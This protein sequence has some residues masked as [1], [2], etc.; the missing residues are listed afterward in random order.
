MNFLKQLIKEVGDEHTSL[1]EDGA[2]SAEFTGYIDTGSLIFNAALSGTIFGGMPDNK[3]LALAGQEAVGKTF[4][5]LGLCKHF[6]DTHDHAGI[7][8]YMSEPAVTVKMLTDRGIDPK[9]LMFS[10]PMTVQEFKFAVIK[11]ADA[12]VALE[13]QPPLMMVLDSLGNLSTTKEMEDSTEGKDVL[14]MTRAKVIRG[15]F[16]TIG[17]KLARAGIPMVVTNHTYDQMD[18]Y[19]PKMMSGGGGLKYAGDMIAFLTKSKDQDDDKE[20][21]VH[22]DIVHISMQK[23]RFSRPF[24]KVD[25]LL[26]YTTGLDR[27]YGLLPLAV[28]AGVFTKL[29]KGYEYAGKRVY[30]KEIN[31]SPEEFYTEDV[32]RVLDDTARKEFQYG[33]H[34]EDD[35]DTEEVK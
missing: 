3:V 24:T 14:D 27:Y 28:K 2:S 11:F 21:K 35:G 4:F 13:E 10:E 32:L 26:N 9:R 33:T 19:K 12:Y 22:G 25:V 20:K 17:L 29:P 1:A 7:A 31:A 15:V 16:R 34:Q 8:W 30:E 23:A 5:A 6:L 18:Q